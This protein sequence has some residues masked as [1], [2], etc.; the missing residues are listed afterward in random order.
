VQPRSQ[1]GLRDCVSRVRCRD[2]RAT[3]RKEKQ[4]QLDPLIPA[5]LQSRRPT[6]RHILG[7]CA[8][9]PSHVYLLDVSK[10]SHSPY[11]LLIV[12]GPLRFGHYY[13]YPTPSKSK[14]QTKRAQRL[15]VVDVTCWHF[16][17]IL[18]HDKAQY[19][20]LGRSSSLRIGPLKEQTSTFGLKSVVFATMLTVTA[21]CSSEVWNPIESLRIK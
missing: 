11:A 3:C 1:C 5:A 9:P 13:A 7:T 16:Y 4:Q 14:L 18:F 17:P 6:R 19:L 12:Y 20:C 10:V 15:T 2:R 8:T 21:C